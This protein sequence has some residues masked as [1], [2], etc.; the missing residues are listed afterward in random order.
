MK[1]IKTVCVY[2]ASSS[3]VDKEY[4][5]AAVELGKILAVHD[6]TCV[7]G[8]GNQGLMGTLSDSVLESGGKVIGVIPRFMQDEGWCHNN[9]TRIITTKDMHERKQTM[10]NLSDAVIAMPGG[11]GTLEE[12]LEIIT[13]KQLG[14][15]L[16]PIVILNTKGYYDG[17]IELFDRAIRESFMRPEHSKL[18]ETATSPTE[19]L[20]AFYRSQEWDGSIRKIAAI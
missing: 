20:P 17:L 1:K 14:L 2:C 5:G 3:K 11:C 10:A 18:W 13:W 15:Y 19:V 8:G 7:C 12:L 4:F 9:L 6:I 16:N